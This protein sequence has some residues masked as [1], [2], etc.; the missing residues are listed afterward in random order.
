MYAL[1]QVLWVV[2]LGLSVA[3]A[4]KMAVRHLWRTYIWFFV[5][6]CFQILRS[7]ILLPIP[8]ESTWYAW[9]FLAS[10]PVLWLIYILVVLELY[11]LVFAGYKGIA[12]LS[13]WAVA[14]SLGAAVGISALTLSADLARPAGRYEVLVYYS[15]IERGLLFSLVV[16]LLLIT[17]FLLWFP[18][19]IRRNLVLHASIYSVYFLSLTFALFVR[20]VAGYEVTP[21]VN[22]VLLFIDVVCFGQWLSRFNEAGEVE[23]ASLKHKWQAEDEARLLRQMEALDATLLRRSGR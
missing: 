13:R 11:S 20:N 3:L 2:A 10:Q 12:S 1:Q 23:P 6:L 22:V 8:Q 4:V 9:C 7:V 18:I 16:F 19:A 15:V 21:A 14:A 5:F 17:I